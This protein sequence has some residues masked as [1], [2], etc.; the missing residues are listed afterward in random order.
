MGEEFE[1]E[2]EET[3]ALGE[4]EEVVKKREVRKD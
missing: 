1:R 2:E 3:E 4:D